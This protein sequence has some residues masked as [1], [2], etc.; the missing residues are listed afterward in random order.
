MWSCCV[1]GQ[2]CK[3]LPHALSRVPAGERCCLQGPVFLPQLIKPPGAHVLADS[4]FS[5]HHTRCS[6][7]HTGIC[8]LRTW[9]LEQD[10]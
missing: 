9:G 4:R 6:L 3:L 10:D 5:H 1:L 7:K 2:E 8:N